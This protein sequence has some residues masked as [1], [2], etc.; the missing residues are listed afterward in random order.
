MIKKITGHRFLPLI[1]AFFF[2]LLFT[3]QALVYIHQLPSTLDEG[4]YLYKGY[5]F[6]T[7]AIKPFQQYSVWTNKMPLAFLI[8]GT[9]QALFQPG[10]MTGRIFA[11]IQGL[12][13]LFSM[14]WFIRREANAWLAAAAVGVVA[15]NP[16]L[17]RMYSQAL[18]EGVVSS[19]LM[20]AVVI[21]VG[22][23]RKTWHLVLSSLL[24]AATVLTRENML[25]IMGFFFIYLVFEYGWKKTFIAVIPGA[26]ILLL[27]H[28]IYWPDIV[29]HIWRQWL[30]GPLQAY[31]PLLPGAKFV[32]DVSLMSRVYSFWQGVRYHFAMMFGLVMLV[33]LLPPKTAWKDKTSLRVVLF[34][35]ITVVTMIAAHAWAALWKDYCVFCFGLYLNFFSVLGVTLIAL[36]LPLLRKQAALLVNILA[37][38]AILIFSTGIGFGAHQELDNSLMSMTVPRIKDMQIQ[39]GTTELWRLLA[40]K[41]SLSFDQLSWI[42]PAAFG[43]LAGILVLLIF[44]GLYRRNKRQYSWA[45]YSLMAFFIIGLLLSPTAIFGNSEEEDCGGDVIGTVEA[46]GKHIGSLIPPGSTVYWEGGLSPAPLLYVPG[47]K[48]YGPQLNDGY[49]FREDVDSDKLYR[50]GF[51]NADL[52]RKWINEADYLLIVDYG[53][54]QGYNTMINMDTY[55]E[56]PMTGFIASCRANSKIH[57]FKRIK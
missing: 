6:A 53:Y 52:Q 42:I 35:F 45:T 46:A 48:V 15:I 37:G 18:S 22:H 14:W 4:N 16:G 27:V 55:E 21:G 8:P 44:W 28:I 50:Y 32:M 24:F 9:A 54:K 47:I 2:A 39:P 30:P 23:N 26:V 13:T 12:V 7:G 43:L 17:V 20:T 40:N 19:L 51:W 5:L 38:I 29:T 3:G 57:V 36:C 34:L 41:F 33:L 11:I 49:A 1:V 10:L 25:P 31:F 56:L